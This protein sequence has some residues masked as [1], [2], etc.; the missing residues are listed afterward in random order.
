MERKFEKFVGGPTQSTHDRIYI[1]LNKANLITMNNNCY[2][3]LRKPAA[4]NLYYSRVDD[5]IAIEP[6]DNLRSPST[7]PVKPKS[8]SGWCIHAS[9]FCKHFNIR[10]TTTER[11]ITPAF[12]DGALHLKLSETVTVRHHK[13]DK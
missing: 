3:M 1:S 11:F 6:L 8:S 9:P 4:V 12:V 2:R 5:I 13:R 7:F 10:L